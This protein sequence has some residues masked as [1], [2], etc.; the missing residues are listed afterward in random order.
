MFDN[1]VH[2]VLS[3]VHSLNF[4]LVTGNKNNP[5]SHDRAVPMTMHDLVL[6]NWTNHYL[7]ELHSQMS[8]RARKSKKKLESQLAHAI[9]MPPHSPGVWAVTHGLNFD[10]AW[11]KK[12]TAPSVDDDDVTSDNIA[13]LF[14]LIA[15]Y[16]NLASK[17]ELDDSWFPFV[18][19]VAFLLGII[20]S[21]LAAFRHYATW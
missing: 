20:C 6:Y 17:Y 8:F 2:T 19:I 11:V 9:L 10:T 5:V 14:L 4:T 7:L 1:V 3:S 12:I 15:S 16:S 18:S 21:P 13:Y